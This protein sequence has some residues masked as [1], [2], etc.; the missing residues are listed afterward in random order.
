MASN[1]DSDDMYD[2]AKLETVTTFECKYIL[3]QSR[4]GIC[5]FFVFGQWTDDV[6]I[7]N[8]VLKLNSRG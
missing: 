3:E 4:G 8:I 1:E 2:W 6:Y 7:I 5:I